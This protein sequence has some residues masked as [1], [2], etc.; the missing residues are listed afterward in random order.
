[1]STGLRNGGSAINYRVLMEVGEN[2]MKGQSPQVAA[3]NA[4]IKLATFKKWRAAYESGKAGSKIR[5]LFEKIQE[6]E[7]MALSIA[8]T[9]LYQI[10]AG[11]AK[12]TGKEEPTSAAKRLALDALKFQLQSRAKDTY[13]NKTAEERD[14]DGKVDEVIVTWRG[15]SLKETS[16]TSETS[17][18]TSPSEDSTTP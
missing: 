3:V 1:M 8:E 9:V 15:R 14:E 13:G 10:V 17:E 4:G 18:S 16:T 6:S 7:A 2:I 11:G 5:Q 12:V